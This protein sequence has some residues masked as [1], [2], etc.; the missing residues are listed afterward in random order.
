MLLGPRLFKE[1]NAFAA[2]GDDDTGTGATE[3]DLEEQA[4]GYQAAY[5]KLAAA[6]AP[7]RD[8]VAYAEDVCLH[9]A[10]EFTRL[11]S[12]EPGMDARRAGGPEPSESVLV[13][14]RGLCLVY[15]STIDGQGGDSDRS[16]QIYKMRI[17][18]RV[19]L[20]DRSCRQP[21]EYAQRLAL[22]GRVALY[23]LIVRPKQPIV[24]FL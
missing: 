21:Q 3:I 14:S 2:P 15:D 19:Q 13:E 22:R 24:A 16:G 7:A 5:S 1:T 23:R 18:I 17:T 12:A 4:A 8:V 9:V 6:G 20:M 11:L 10:R